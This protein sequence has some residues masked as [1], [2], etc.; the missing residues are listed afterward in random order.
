MFAK[1]KKPGAGIEFKTTASLFHGT[2]AQ[3][4]DLLVVKANGS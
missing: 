3:E 1:R 4:S 2:Y